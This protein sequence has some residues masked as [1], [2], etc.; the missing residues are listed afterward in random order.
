MKT[1]ITVL[2]VTAIF[3]LSAQEADTTWKKGGTIGVNFSQV[4]LK[5]WS[6]GGDNSLALNSLLSLY[7]NYFLEKT[8]WENSLELGY[9]IVKQGSAGTRKSDDKIIFVSKYGRDFIGP[10]K[11]S[12][13]LDFRTQ[14]ANG[15]D[16]GVPDSLRKPISKFM[17]PAAITLALGA[18]YRPND[19]FSAMISPVTGKATVVLDSRLSDAGA[20]GLDPGKKV[21]SEFGWFINC[22]YQTPVMKG[23]DFTSK[24]NLFSA[25]NKAKEIDVNWEN[26]L[27]M[28][29]NEYV[30]ASFTAQLVYDKD[31]VNKWQV[32]EVFAAGLLY[33]F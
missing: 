25:Y 20:F 1:W 26:L 7:A 8:R 3:S 19:M 9:G 4:Q 18:N 31:V 33:K 32:K 24:L 15:Y 30:S 28:K 2:L 11:Y 5:D 12:A 23:I 17:S 6:G 27:L 14:F 16:Y 22:V 10:W 21:L 13:L 29:V